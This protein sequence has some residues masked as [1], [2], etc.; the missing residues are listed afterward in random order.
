[1]KSVITALIMLFLSSGLFTTTWACASC[2]A[3]EGGAGVEVSEK[4]EATITL[5]VRGMMKSRS[6]AT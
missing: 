1:M 5:V 2:R 3:P 6:G 4:R